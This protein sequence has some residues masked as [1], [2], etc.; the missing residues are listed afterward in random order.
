MTLMFSFLS[1]EFAICFIV[2]YIAYWLCQRHIHLQNALL[3]LFSYICIYF[4]SNMYAVGL[5][6][7]Y[8]LSIY[9][10]SYAL[11]RFHKYKT[12]IVRLA[13]IVT[14]LQLSVFKYFDFFKTQTDQVLHA[15]HA[16]SAWLWSDLI[17]PLGLSYYSFQSISYL[18]DRAKQN[19]PL[20]RLSC[21]QACTYFSLL[22]T[23]TAGP[24][25]RVYEAKG[26]TAVDGESSAMGRQLNSIH[27]RQVVYP[28]FALFLILLALIK[29]WWIASWIATQWVNPVFQ[30]PLQYQSFEVL[31]AIYG[32]TLQLFL[33]FSGYSELMLG[34][35]LLLG[36]KLPVN[37]R[38]PLLAY[39]IRDFW[40]RWHISLSTWIRDYIYIPLGGSRGSLARTQAHLLLAMVLSG[41]WH[42]AG[43][44]F[45]IWG[46]LHGFALILLN[47]ADL[48][49]HRLGVKD[50]RNA[51]A[52]TGRL[53]R[54]IGRVVTVHF[55]CLAFIFF[56]AKTLTDANEIFQALAF[57]MF[58]V[59]LTTNPFYMLSLL[60]L[61]WIIYPFIY[62]RLGQPNVIYSFKLTPRSFVPLFIVFVVVLI[63]APSGIPGF[64]YANF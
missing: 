44:G 3:M 27:P 5:L 56:Q 42:G 35:A 55:V 6:L 10:A 61:A 31:A 37:F 14:L 13:V 21:L 16:D 59:P 46:A 29:K 58:D 33:D 7:I 62:Q 38:A 40:D 28:G 60:L 11:D 15:L 52:N 34:F 54:V 50:R 17:M 49:A 1:I 22:F 45:V 32:Y 12:W 57:N 41:I 39:N 53:G 8:S 63:C 2:F 51:L 24:I 47:L 26:L 30:N 43:W 20:P 25:A 4:M 19:V 64:I 48:L 18:V 23:I 9:A 36:F